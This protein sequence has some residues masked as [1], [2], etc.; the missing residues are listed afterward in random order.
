RSEICPRRS[1]T[2]AGVITE[3]HSP[4]NEWS[5]VKLLPRAERS[6]K[7]SVSCTSC[8]ARPREKAYRADTLFRAVSWW[9]ALNEN[10]ACEELVSNSPRYSATGERGNFKPA[11]R[12]GVS[13]HSSPDSHSCSHAT[14]KNVRSRLMGPLMEVPG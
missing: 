11:S 9:F 4:T 12:A 1:F 13:D 2:I 14:E 3:I 7:F 5:W 6:V 8:D 10:S